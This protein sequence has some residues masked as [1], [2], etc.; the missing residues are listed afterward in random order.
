MVRP[1]P[2]D[3]LRL[4]VEHELALIH[5]ALELSQ[6]DQPLGA[7]PV[8]LAA[9]PGGGSGTDL[10]LVHRHVCVTQQSFDVLGVFR[11]DSDSQAAAD[12]H[13]QSLEQERLTQRT[14]ERIG[15]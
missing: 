4:V 7:A 5:G 14:Q 13:P 1:V 15:D 2:S 3:D 8:A 9:I 6:H 11:T 12:R 10:G